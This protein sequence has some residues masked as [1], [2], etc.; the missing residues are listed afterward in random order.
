MKALPVGI[1]AVSTIFCYCR[2]SS[3]LYCYSP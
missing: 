1:S 3:R 2:I